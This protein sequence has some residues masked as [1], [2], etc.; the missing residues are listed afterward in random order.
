MPTG[1]CR[2]SELRLQPFKPSPSTNKLKTADAAEHHPR[3]LRAEVRIQRLSANNPWGFRVARRRFDPRN[4]ANRPK[5][6]N[7]RLPVA[8]ASESKARFELAVNHTGLAFGAYHRHKLCLFGRSLAKFLRLR[9]V[10]FDFFLNVSIGST[11]NLIAAPCFVSSR[12]DPRSTI[13]RSISVRLSSKLIKLAAPFQI[14]D[15]HA[16]ILVG[17]CPC[18]VAEFLFQ[19]NNISRCARLLAGQATPDRI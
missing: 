18:R 5:R 7:S 15:R 13:T 19:V 10:L 3:Q 9:P 4:I 6:H 12:L 1:T 17:C 2:F 14:V 16:T 8:G 11:T